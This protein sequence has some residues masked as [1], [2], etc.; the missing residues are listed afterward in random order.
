LENTKNRFL[1]FLTRIFRHFLISNAD[2]LY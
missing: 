2:Y 1:Y